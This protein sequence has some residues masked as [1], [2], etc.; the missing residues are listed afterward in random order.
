M[1]RIH[2]RFHRA[3]MRALTVAVVAA[4]VA[5]PSSAQYFGRNKVPYE[6]FHFDVLRTSHFDVH[7]Y[8]EERAAAQDAARMLERWN[9]RLSELFNHQLSERKPVVIYA[10]HPDFQQT[11]VIADQLDEGTG[12]VTESLLDR[13]VLPLTGSYAESDHVLGHEAVHVFQYDIAARHKGGATS[14]ERLPLWLIEGMAEYLSVGSQDPH[15]A[16]WLRDAIQRN[17][18]PTIDQLT[19]NPKYFPYRFGEA[20]WAYIGGTWGDEVVPRLFKSSLERGF[21]EGVKRVLGMSVDS[22]SRRWHSTVRTAYA[23]L[24]EGRTPPRATGSALIGNGRG[25]EYNVAPS[26]SPDGIL[27][28]F[29]STRNFRGVELLIGDAK[30]GEVRA[31][32]ASPGL[33]TRFDALSFLYT[34][35]TWSPDSRR[36]AFVTYA[37]GNNEI[38]I[39]DVG[40][41]RIVRRIK[42]ED[43][44]AISSLSWSPDGSRIAFSGSQG[45]VSDLYLFELGTGRTR[46]L[47]NDAFA[48]LQPSWSPDGESIAFVTDRGSTGGETVTAGSDFKALSYAPLRLAILDVRKASIRILPAFGQAKHLNPQFAPDGNSIYFVSDEGGFSDIYRIEV[49]TG[50]I[51]QITRSATGVSG[52]AAT[53]PAISVARENGTLLFSVFEGGTFDIRAITAAAL[54]DGATLGDDNAGQQGDGAQ[55]TPNAAQLP[56]E[57]RPFLKIID[58]YLA[59]AATGLPADSSFS[60][61]G[62]NPGLRLAMIGQPSLGVGFGGGFGTQIVGSAAAY[63]TDV[64]GNHFLG[65]AAVGNGS[66]QDLGGQVFYLN[67][68]HRWSWGTSLE[69]IPYVTGYA[70]VSA[71]T[72]GTAVD[73]TLAHIAVSGASML[74]QYA[75]SQTQR[76]ELS[77]GVRHVGYSFETVREVYAGNRLVGTRRTAMEAP[78]S[79]RMATASIALV[80][81]D[82]AN[83]FSSPISG[84]R[85]RLEV[86]PTVGSLSYQ[87]YLMDYRRYFF[88]KPVTLAVRGLHYGRYGRDADSDRLGYVFLGD[89]GLVRGYAY[90]SFNSSDCVAGGSGSLA[91]ST[92]PQF[93]RLIGSRLALA[94]VELRIPL[95]GQ[96]GLG[97]VETIFPPIE[98]APFVDAGVAW[99]R[100]SAPVMQ[101]VANSAERTPVMSTGV[102][103]RINLFGFAIGQVYYAHPFQR[104][105]RGGVW[106]FVLEPGW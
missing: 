100:A 103:A 95:L 85:Y 11:N 101:F 2:P 88:R 96:R 49:E 52:I 104:P 66:I 26:V 40:T 72:G 27:F 24:L 69:R 45:G 36:L 70:Q 15:T 35:G 29:F 19:T 55:N 62:Y 42:P 90:D 34:S 16:M 94:N 48:D 87:T 92:C 74:G 82:A 30:T 60:T 93:D 23:P 67:S 84:T 89:P 68:E 18:L 51:F 10:D 14:L 12:G 106:G 20:L 28:A 91:S 57:R 56:S 59:D 86:T 79:L 21:E 9:T 54:G 99:T 97:L 31:T 17:D 7:Y 58:D 47:T 41:R 76:V 63:F 1:F 33:S 65:V 81:D 22:L 98:I 6:R 73:Y 4:S 71:T 5:T 78:T 13:M 102:A 25:N 53:S 75:R 61:H 39:V 38:D 83:G 50:A 37:D 32:V 77:G 80:G 64:L 44:G 8:N 105:S 3:A 43:V 46:R